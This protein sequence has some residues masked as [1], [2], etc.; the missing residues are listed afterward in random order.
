MFKNI[1][2]KSK[3]PEKS[4][5]II[6][7]RKLNYWIILIINILNYPYFIQKTQSI[8]YYFLQNFELVKII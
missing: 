7:Y 5:L 3:K 6:S 4:Y 1:T 8:Q 2:Y